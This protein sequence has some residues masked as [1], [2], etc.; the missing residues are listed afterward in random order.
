[1]QV[2][3]H[4]YWLHAGFITLVL[5]WLIQALLKGLAGKGSAVDLGEWIAIAL[6]FVIGGLLYGGILSL[7]QA[8]AQLQARNQVLNTALQQ[9]TQQLQAAQITLPPTDPELSDLK[10]NFFSIASHELRTPLSTIL[11]CSQLL[12]RPGANESPAKRQRNLRRIQASAKAM[13]QLLADLLLLTRAEA[14]QLE[15]TP[16]KIELLSFCDAVLAEVEQAMREPRPLSFVAIGERDFAVSDEVV[17]RSI[18]INLLNL[19]T[20]Y[21]GAAGEVMLHVQGDAGQ[22]A[23]QICVEDAALSAAARA[24]LLRSL[25]PEAQAQTKTGL[26]IVQKCLELHQGTMTVQSEPNGAI[27]IGVELPWLVEENLHI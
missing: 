16:R 10:L 19:V 8:Q 18:L 12:D 1:M 2:F 5:L 4:P 20:K 13:T 6:C 23:L 24:K 11:V 17:L 14:G 15:L 22:L 3:R 25:V 26:A 21:L 27:A 9:E 7:L